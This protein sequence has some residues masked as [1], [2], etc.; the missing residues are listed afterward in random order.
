MRVGRPVFASVYIYSLVVRPE[1]RFVNKSKAASRHIK[2][3]KVIQICRKM[4]N[5]LIYE[6]QENLQGKAPMAFGEIKRERPKLAAIANK[7]VYNEN[8]SV[9]QVRKM[10]CR[11]S[12]IL[13]SN[14]SGVGYQDSEGFRDDVDSG[15]WSVQG[16]KHLRLEGCTARKAFR[17]GARG[18][19]RQLDPQRDERGLVR[20]WC[21]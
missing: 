5:F 1:L 2:V 20:R 19:E 13:P 4:S 9:N 11:F 16:E 7:G 14:A 10:F 12:R 8:A 17:Q 18:V 21:A 3:E 6:D 15:Q